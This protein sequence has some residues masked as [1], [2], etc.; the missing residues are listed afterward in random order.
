MQL[1]PLS[2]SHIYII[3]LSPVLSLTS[4]QFIENLPLLQQSSLLNELLIFI[5]HG[6]ENLGLLQMQYT[7]EIPSVSQTSQQMSGFHPFI[8]YTHGLYETNSYAASLF[9]TPHWET[10]SSHRTYKV[11]QVWIKVRNTF[12]NL[13]ADCK[14][15]RKRH[16]LHLQLASLAGQIKSSILSLFGLKRGF[17]TFHTKHSMQWQTP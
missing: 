17:C 14:N 15:G 7:L 8:R 6:F 1:S 12:L 4:L 5:S 16:S 2:L 13:Q 3:T 11:F 10:I 9:L